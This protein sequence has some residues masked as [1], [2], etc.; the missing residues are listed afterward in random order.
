MAF[1]IDVVILQINSRQLHY[2]RIYKQNY[3]CDYC[4]CILGAAALESEVVIF[5]SESVALHTNT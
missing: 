1:T 4:I 5:G 3:L 2:D